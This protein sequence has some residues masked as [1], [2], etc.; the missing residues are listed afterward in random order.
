MPD[1]LSL[2]GS[3]PALPHLQVPLSRGADADL[4][5]ADSSRQIQA[6]QSRH[7]MPLVANQLQKSR[8]PQIQL[9]KLHAPPTQHNE[10]PVPQAGSL[11][12]EEGSLGDSALNRR[13]E[14]EH[15]ADTDPLRHAEPSSSGQALRAEG[16]P[17]GVR[18][19]RDATHAGE[20]SQAASSRSLQRLTTVRLRVSEGAGLGAGTTAMNAVFEA[21]TLGP[22][23]EEKH[24]GNPYQASPVSMQL[25]WAG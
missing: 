24:R 14:E 9:E 20:L 18:G 11:R 4:V 25:Y 5:A 17:S 12:R 2:R 10:P 7:Q 8:I 19:L 16:S 21:E 6:S 13:V 15:E 3:G 1:G 23:H 22:G